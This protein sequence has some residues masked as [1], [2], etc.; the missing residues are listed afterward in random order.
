MSLAS[1]DP[2]ADMLARIRNAVAV[3]KNQVVLPHS[4]LKVSVAQ[5]LKQNRY[6]EDY[7]ENDAQVGKTLTLV[8]S[9]DDSNSPI[10]EIKRVSTPGRRVYT[11]AGKIP[12]IKQGRG[13]VIVSTSKG[14]M[15]GEEAKKQ[16]VGGELICEVY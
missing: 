9:G 1:T 3:N 12:T 5:L 14:L 6:L 4:K 16:H 7:Q 13:I 11:A 10:T 8:L 2:I 15:T